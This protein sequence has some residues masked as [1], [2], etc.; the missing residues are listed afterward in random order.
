[1]A[2][3]KTEEKPTLEFLWKEE[4]FRMEIS[5]MLKNGVAFHVESNDLTIKNEKDLEKVIEDYKKLNVGA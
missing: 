2:K 5:D 4:L 1:M 3:K